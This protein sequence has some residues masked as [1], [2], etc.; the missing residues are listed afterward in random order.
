[1]K[2]KKSDIHI[3]IVEDDKDLNDAYRISLGHAGYMVDVA[4]NGEEALKL[5]DTLPRD[6]DI[7]LLDLRMPVLDGVGFL[8]EFRPGKHPDCT[9]VVFTNYDSHSDIDRAYKLGVSR[10]VL[11]ARTSPNDLLH[12]VESIVSEK[13][14]VSA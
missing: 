5:I 4:M 1:M 6:P 2:R 8:E 3:L 11:K 10:Y 7:I 12:I 9:V 14:L 13:K